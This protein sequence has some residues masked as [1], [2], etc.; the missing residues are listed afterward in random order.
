MKYL[1][2]LLKS[3]TFW[4]NAAAGAI[5]ILNKHMG[6]IVPPDYIPMATALANIANRFLTTKSLAEK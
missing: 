6:D 3:K 4:L 5:A 1:K 2:G